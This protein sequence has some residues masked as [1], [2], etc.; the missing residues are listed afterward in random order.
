[1]TD[2]PGPRTV[3]DVRPPL[4]RQ[5]RTASL[6]ALFVV[7]GIVLCTGP[8]LVLPFGVLTFLFFAPPALYQLVMVLRGRP[9]VVVDDSGLTDHASPAGIGRL[10]W[11]RVRGAR[12][13]Q[14]DRRSPLVVVEVDDPDGL[15]RGSGP[16]LRR[17]RRSSQERFGSPVVIPVR[18]LGV[19]PDALCSAIRGR[20]AART[21]GA[22]DRG[23]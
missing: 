8:L 21:N 6:A 18:G 12:V 11:E 1:M 10:G 5:V 4:V 13:E 22:G 15:L 20:S 17:A 2:R 9:R 7:A 23:Q 14:V 3:L 19:H 16:L